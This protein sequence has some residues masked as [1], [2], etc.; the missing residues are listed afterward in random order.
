MDT[1]KN[2]D[3]EIEEN[4]AA[5]R[6][7]RLYGPAVV[8]SVERGS[9]ADRA[10]LKSC[11]LIW[12]I[13]GERLRDM[14]D[15]YVLTAD[16]VPHR[17]D[18]EGGGGR[19]EV[20]IDSA[21]SLSGIEIEQ[22]LFGEV[23]TCN[24]NCMFC[25]VDQLPDGLRDTFYVKDDDYRLSFLCGNFVTLTN[26]GRQELERISEER[27]SPLYVSLHS[28]EPDVRRE[29]FGGSR[30]EAGLRA[31][32]KLLKDPWI[33]V[34]LQIVLVRGINDGEHL[35]ATLED[36]ASRFGDVR[37]IG[38]VPVGMTTTGRH[39]LDPAYSFD[40][41]SSLEVIEQL[42]DW[43][44]EFGASGPF[45]ADEFFYLA[46]QDPPA[47]SHYA[48]FPQ[49]ENGIGMTRW[50]RD[51]FEKAV[52]R[53]RRKLVGAGGTAIVTTPMGA[54]ALGPLRLENYGAHQVVCSNSLFGEKVTVCGLLPG[55]DVI[56]SLEAVDGIE[57]VLV[58]EVALLDQT[59][60]VD[61]VTVKE[62]EDAARSKILT[63]PDDPGALL[64]ALTRNGR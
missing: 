44:A 20:T 41:S 39:P 15:V 48:G 55:R 6:G 21:G 11:E 13:D 50:F 60:F 47:T 34:H 22:P 5:D 36:I 40:R 51:S 17:Y 23:V 26:V 12:R 56:S 64:G 30:S 24:N 4:G 10:G 49:I 42:T 33:D 58:P 52:R 38:V 3:G 14:I 28:T 54:W 45:A 63:V 16:D 18:V 57:R 31:L 19:R 29:M 46:G 62:V 59:E 61:G 27:L 1:E 25:F 7:E 32:G 2:G 35:D 9:P 37:S 53:K 8:S 43:R